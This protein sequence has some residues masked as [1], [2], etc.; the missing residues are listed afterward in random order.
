VGDPERTDHL[1]LPIA[2]FGPPGRGAC[3]RT[4][5]AAASASIGSDL[6]P[7]MTTLE[8]AIQKSTTRPSLSVHYTSFLWVLLQELVR[9]TTH[10]FVACRGAGLPFSDI[11]PPSPWRSKSSLVGFES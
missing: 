9:S 1:N 8:N 11:A 4:A 6:P 2:I 3:Q 5:R 7:L 10:H